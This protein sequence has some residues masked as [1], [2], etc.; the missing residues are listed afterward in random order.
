[1]AGGIRAP[2]AVASDGIRLQV[3]ALWAER[4]ASGRGPPETAERRISGVLRHLPE[5]VGPD[6]AGELREE[7]VLPLLLAGVRPIALLVFPTSCLLPRMGR[8]SS[9]GDRAWQAYTTSKAW[10]ASS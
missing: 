4:L 10:T 6:I 7:E 5:H 2:E 3:A 1:H 8:R 9:G